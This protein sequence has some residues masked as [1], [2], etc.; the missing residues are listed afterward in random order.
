MDEVFRATEELKTQLRA[1]LQKRIDTCKYWMNIHNERWKEEHLIS[2]INMVIAY[3]AAI[4]EL[5]W[6]SREIEYA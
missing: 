2:D 1:E 6:A 5:E 3:N 4:N